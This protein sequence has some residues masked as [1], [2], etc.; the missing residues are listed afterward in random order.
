ML[1]APLLAIDQIQIHEQRLFQHDPEWAWSIIRKVGQA[2]GQRL[3]EDFP[4]FKP[5]PRAPRILV[6]CGKGHNTADALQVA[7]YW[8]Q[9]RPRSSIDLLFTTET[10]KPLTQRSLD[11]LNHTCQPHV[12]SIQEGWPIQKDY[13]LVLDGIL[14]LNGQKPLS[15]AYAQLI[16]RVQEHVDG[17]KVAIDIPSGLLAPE[18]GCF[19]ADLTYCIGMPKACLTWTHNQP[20]VGRLRYVDVGLFD[21]LDP[22]LHETH[23]KVIFKTNLRSLHG[24]RFAYTH[25]Y[26]YGCVAI[27]AGSMHEDTLQYPGAALM[28]AKAALYAGAGLVY[29][30]VPAAL[31]PAYAAECPEIIWQSQAV[32]SIVE[33]LRSIKNLQALLIGPGLGKKHLIMDQLE[34][35]TAAIDCPIIF[36]ADLLQ[37]NLWPLLVHRKARQQLNILTPHAGEWHRLKTFAQNFDFEEVARRD[38]QSVQAIPEQIDS[39][40]NS[41]ACFLERSPAE[42]YAQQTG[43]I[44]VLKGPLTQVID[45]NNSY[46]IWGGNPIL[47][48][49]GTGDILAGLIAG[50]IAQQKPANVV[51]AVALATLWHS[52]TADYWASHTGERA[53]RTTEFFKYLG[54]TLRQF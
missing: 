43:S 31:I 35:V 54:P 51:E 21:H 47:A 53:T 5:L 13:D 20:W 34:A 16:Q 28:A 24:L 37:P 14:G 12:Q 10:L 19:K 52:E 49:G 46:H 39:C 2:V 18:K 7:Q 27:I 30:Y 32:P 33:Q 15:T 22:S 25:K 45:A 42:E 4:I 29:A 1:S 36:D 26:D 41:K 50:C 3:L 8:A 38:L 11:S 9:A 48:R 44:L 23:Q 40:R 6:L 17:L